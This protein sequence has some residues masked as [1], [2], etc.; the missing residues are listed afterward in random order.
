MIR[1]FLF[2]C[3]ISSISCFSQKEKEKIKWE[4]NQPLVWTDFKGKPNALS[5]FKANTNAGIS[6]S[7][8]YSER[9]GSTELNYVIESYFYPQLSW[10]KEIDNKEYLLAH[11][12]LHFDIAELHARMFRKALSNYTIGKNLKKDLVALYKKYEQQQVTMQR[13]FDAETN[14]SKIREAEMK[15]REFVKQEL[16]EYQAYAD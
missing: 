12:Q 15:W 2:I 4:E 1:I 5:P 9:D 11:E 7:Y 8:N 16:E 13:E 3:L 6:F 10:K 14:H